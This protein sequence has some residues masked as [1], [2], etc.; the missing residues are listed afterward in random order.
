MHFC[1]GTHLARL[2]IRILVDAFLRRVPR[3]SFDMSRA[4]RPPSSFQWGW[5]TLPVVIG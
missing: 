1:I 2:E 3:F 5:N 4:V